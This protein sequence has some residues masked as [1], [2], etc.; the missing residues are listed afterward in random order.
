MSVADLCTQSLTEVAALIERRELSPVELTRAVLDRID[1]LDG[2]LHSYLTVTPERAL[3]AARAAEAEIGRGAWRGPLH[4]VPIGI[5]DL[6]DTRGVRT[7]CASGVRAEHV[8]ERDAT[9]V[10]RLE[11]AGAV[12]VGKLNLTEFALMGYHPTLPIPHNPWD[13]SRDTGGSSSGAGAAAAAGLCFAAIGTDTG[14]SI[15]MPSAWCGVVGLKPTYGRVSRAGVFPLGA[16]FDHVGPMARRVADTAVMLDAIA[17][18]DP[19]DLTSLRDAPPRCAAAIGGTARGVRIGWDE[20]FVASGCQPD[21]TEAVRQAV[22]ALAAQGAQ[23]VELELPPVDAVLQAWPVLCAAEAAVAHAPTF[24]SRA[25]DYGPTFRSFLEYSTTLT[26][27]DYAAGHETRLV[28]NGGLRGVFEQVDVF[29]CPSTF[30]P[31]PRADV[32]DPHLV[33][34]ADFVPFMAP[35]MR[36]TAPFNYSG[37]PTLS[38]PCGFSADGLPYSLQL[39]GRHGDEALLCRVGHAYEE[40]TEWHRRRPPLG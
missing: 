13:L 30:M 1:R 25:A 36:F 4:G 24:P 33:F 18:F 19:D 5:K 6:C 35:F 32:L 21:V 9:V 16:S 26:A 15:R 14:G 2:Q 31:A 8:P 23:I 37:S 10:R 40:A 20:R 28:W 22:R 39:V 38:V 11:S 27:R 7:T 17:G 12:I 3:A 29:A 34:T